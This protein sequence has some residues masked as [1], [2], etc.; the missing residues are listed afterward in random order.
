MGQDA[1]GTSW[2]TNGPVRT[3]IEDIVVSDTIDAESV[4]HVRLWDQFE[5]LK[6]TLSHDP[7]VGQIIDDLNWIYRQDGDG[8]R[9]IPSLT[10]IYTFQ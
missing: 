6:W 7:E 5:A 4:I 1:I 8:N 9:Q 2:L 3:V 10:V